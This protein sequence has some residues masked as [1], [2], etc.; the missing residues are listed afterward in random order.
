MIRFWFKK[1]FAVILSLW[2]LMTLTFF[3]LLYLPGSPF[4]GE[5]KIN[6]AILENLAGS[7]S[8]QHSFSEKYWSYLRELVKGELGPSLSQPGQNVENIIVR[9]FSVSFKLNLLAALF[10]LFGGISLGLMAAYSSSERFK[11]GLIYTSTLVVG[12]PALFLS[13]L[14]IYFFALRWSWLPAAQL[15]SASSYIL[16]L[17][18]LSLRPLMLVARFFF[19]RCLD[20][21]NQPYIQAAVARGL[22]RFQIYFVHI[23]KLAIVP[24]I[25]YSVP[26]I[27]GLLSGSFLVEVLFAIPGLGLE[28]VNAL[29]ARDY[30][31]V[32]GIT[33]IIGALMVI[34]SQIAEGLVYYLDPRLQDSSLQGEEP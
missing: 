19:L 14:L 34:F 2:F 27:V 23:L 4:S 32:V 8:T 18:A 25:S 11:K 7:W 21:E 17:V 5:E 26:I 31:V 24:M 1:F 12:L 30:P 16:P 33:L 10:S 6:P 3:A 13:P 20:F 29:S 15:E 22:S 9:A 28:F